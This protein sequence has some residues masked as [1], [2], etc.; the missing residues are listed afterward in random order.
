MRE[1]WRAFYRLYRLSR[2]T[3]R[4]N[5]LMSGLFDS[6]RV[7]GFHDWV[8]MANQREGPTDKSVPAFLRRK[9]LEMARKRRLYGQQLELWDALRPLDQKAARKVSSEMGIEMTPDEV[10]EIRHRVVRS[11]RRLAEEHGVAV[12][13]DEI[14]MLRMISRAVREG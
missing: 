4:P 9:I 14:G 1:Q 12:P 11:A 13:A 10:A 2:K 5:G 7:L 3:E 6:L 8:A